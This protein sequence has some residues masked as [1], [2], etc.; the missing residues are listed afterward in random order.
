VLA[1]VQRFGWNSSSFQVLEPGYRYFFDGD[2]ACVAYTSAGG[3]WVAAGAPVAPLPRQP[4]VARRFVQ[5]AR[6]AGRRAV[7]ALTEP[8]FVTAAAP[9]FTALQMGEQP[10]WDP[11]AWPETLKRRSSLR[12]QLRRARAK[13]VVVRA[14]DPSELERPEQPLRRAIERLV[15][16]WLH[17][18]SMATLGFLVQVW[19][20]DALSERRI[21]VAHRGGQLCAIAALVPIYA[22]NGFMVEDLLRAPDAPNGTTELL[23]DRVLRDCAARGCGYVT[24]GLAPLAG[25]VE[26]G[27]RAARWLGRGLFDF[28]G[29]RAFKA[30]FVPNEWTPIYLSY[31]RDQPPLL[32]LYAM[33]AAFAKGS[34]TR[35]ALATLLRG[36]RPIVHALIALLVPWTLALSLLDARRYFPSLW[37]KWVWVGFDVALFAALL[38]LARRYRP[39]LARGLA[40]IIALDAGLTFVQA[41]CFNIPRL[42]SGWELL[43]VI[44]AVAA[45]ALAAVVMRNVWRRQRALE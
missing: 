43:G 35:F 42:Q 2:D 10:T 5:A 26:P 25:P 30:K 38:A 44:I 6:R 45:P 28:E 20:F 29:L 3:A 7:L 27:L 13:G 23:I 8:R 15:A 9:E 12:E 17:S 22:R 4:E 16:R 33:L 36:P 11:A 41:L 39:R 14:V 40:A 24:L 31:P 18:R 34:I 21:Y 19:L 37:I 1:L 32:A